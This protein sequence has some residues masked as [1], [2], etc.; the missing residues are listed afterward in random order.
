[1]QEKANDFMKMLEINQETNVGQ[2]NTRWV[3]CW[4]NRWSVLR[5]E[6]RRE[7]NAF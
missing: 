3:R 7:I 4:G 2:M 5:K 1:M 6:T